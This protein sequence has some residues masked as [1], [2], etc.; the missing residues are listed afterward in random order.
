MKR[1]LVVCLL[2]LPTV[3]TP[4]AIVKLGTAGGGLMIYYNNLD[5]N[6]DGVISGYDENVNNQAY[7][8]AQ[9]GYN[10]TNGAPFQF[11]D[12]KY[13]GVSFNDIFSGQPVGQSQF[14][15]DLIGM[16]PTYSP[17][18]GVIPPTVYFADNVDNT[19]AGALLTQVFPTPS[20]AAWAINDYKEPSGPAAGFLTNSLFRGTAFTLNVNSWTVDPTGTLYTMQISGTLI[21]DG[22]IHWYNPA[23]GTTPMSNWGMAGTFLY[24]GTLIY[25]KN[26]TRAGWDYGWNTYANGL[27]NGKDQKDF[28]VGTIE[29]YADV[30]PEPASVTLLAL[31]GLLAGKTKKR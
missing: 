21:T 30:I 13:N 22:Q 20:Q 29:I 3:W 23:L 9:F 14:G 18:G 7:I 6:Q 10:N 2:F 4:A 24:T 11:D 27:E 16:A 12:T 5:W 17:L 15:F 8:R 1:T 31:G 19:P 26:Y 25:D 28:Y